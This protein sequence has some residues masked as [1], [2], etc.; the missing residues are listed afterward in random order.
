VQGLRQGDPIS[1][2]LFV[3]A[4]DVLLRIMVKA[5]DLGVVSS[6]IGI[7]AAQSV[8]IYANDVALFVRPTEV[9]LR[10]VTMALK[11]FSD[12]SGLRVNYHKSSVVLIHGDELDKNRV[13]N[14][15]QCNLGEF[16]CKYLGLQLAIHQLTR[17]E[18]QPM[19]DR[20]KQT[21]PAWQRG[22]LQRSGRLILVKSV[23]ATKPIHHFVIMDV[24]AWVFEEIDQWMRA[25]FWAGKEKT[26]GGQCLV[27]WSTVCKPTCFGGLGVRNLK[28]QALA[29]KVRWEWLKRTDPERSWQGLAMIEDKDA[30]AVFDNM[31]KIEV[32]DGAKVL[33]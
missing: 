18:W 23:I 5:A 27:A 9:D 33:F 19:L 14:L 4:M 21:A 6:F 1:P 3:I 30:R 31:V 15:L 10:F 13:E 2:L 32:G 17:A 16:L 20:A 26:N 25:F 11:A 12:A 7:T 24:P 22:L 29:L 28:L 8:S